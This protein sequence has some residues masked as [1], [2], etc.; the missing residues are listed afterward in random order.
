MVVLGENW[1]HLGAGGIH[2]VV[3]EKI[4]ENEVVRIGGTTPAEVNNPV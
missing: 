2:R 3:A 1:E 4:T